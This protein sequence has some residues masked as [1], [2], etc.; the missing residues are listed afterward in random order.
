M[1]TPAAIFNG[2]VHGKVIELDHAPGLP[3]GEKVTVTV[4]LASGDVK[5]GEGLRRAFGTW[6]DDSEGLDDYL[7]WNRQQ[8]KLGRGELEP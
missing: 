7:E 1:N 8:R 6:A 4:Q 3:D 5:P 2:V